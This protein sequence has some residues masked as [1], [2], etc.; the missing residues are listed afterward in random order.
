MKTKF[1]Y[2][3]LILGL[4]ACN[5]VSEQQI[6]EE[7]QGIIVK[8]DK[9]YLEEGKMI[10]ESTFKVLSS[11]LQQAMA[12]GGIEN[13]LSYC[14]VNAMPLTDSLSK[15]YNVAIKRVSDKARNQLNLASKNEQKIIDNYLASTE[16]RKPVLEQ[17]ENGKITFYAPIVAKALCLN[18]HGIEGEILSSENNEKIKLLY[19][20]DK[21][22]GYSEGDLR[23]V[24]SIMFN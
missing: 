8:T 1:F 6:G 21:A 9:E 3:L 20:E 11:N 14:N 7:V 23:G 13:A 19:P 22:I 10:A 24:W 15:H 12:E 2:M 4:F 16:N 17:N 5:N 18:C